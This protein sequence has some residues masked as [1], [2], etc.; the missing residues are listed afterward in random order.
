[1]KLVMLAKLPPGR[2]KFPANVPAGTCAMPSADIS[3]YLCMRGYFE[4]VAV[5]NSGDA[6]PGGVVDA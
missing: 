2:L 6:R 5:D 4:G 3:H 1:M